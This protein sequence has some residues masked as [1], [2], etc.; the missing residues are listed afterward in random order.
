MDQPSEMWVHH[1]DQDVFVCAEL[2]E[3]GA[4][5]GFVCEVERT[6]G[7]GQRQLLDDAFT[8]LPANVFESTPVIAGRA[9]W[10]IGDGCPA[11]LSDKFVR[12][13]LVTIDGRVQT[14]LQRRR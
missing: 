4:E 11:T 9:E 2:K 8:F 14:L 10:I 6:P 7:H 1:C 3:C 13:A 12:S 5:Q